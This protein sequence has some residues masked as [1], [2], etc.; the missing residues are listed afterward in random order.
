MFISTYSDAV[1]AYKA[2]SNAA[3]YSKTMTVAST[4]NV[5]L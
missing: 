4:V 2:L 3:C 5:I 1:T